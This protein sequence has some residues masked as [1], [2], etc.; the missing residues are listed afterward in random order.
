M[1]TGLRR[2]RSVAD[3]ARIDRPVVP[4]QL[5]EL[6][7]VFV[8][9]PAGRDRVRTVVAG[10]AEETSVTLGHAIERLILIEVAVVV[11]G[12]AARLVQPGLRVLR[13]SLHIT[14]AGKTGLRIRRRQRVS[15][16]GW[17]L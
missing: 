7:A 12:V 3:R 11:A 1:W 15:G 14:V 10:F 9:Q 13:D 8:R 5:E 4:L 16:P 2:R 17:Q 6:Q